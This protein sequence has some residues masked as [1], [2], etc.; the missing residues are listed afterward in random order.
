MPKMKTHKSASKRFK[1]RNSG[2]VARGRTPRDHNLEKKSA[3]RKRH[4]RAD[5]GVSDADK[6][7]VGRMLGIRVS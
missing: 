1:V 3:K 7:R 2:S 5:A 4:M 6:G